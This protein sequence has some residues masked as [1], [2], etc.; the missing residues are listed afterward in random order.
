MKKIFKILKKIVVSSFILYSYNLIAAPLNLIIPINLIT[1]LLLAIV[2]L[3]AL[4]AL[5]AILLI[6]Y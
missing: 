5:I 3:P 4:F 1:I 2:G 6:I